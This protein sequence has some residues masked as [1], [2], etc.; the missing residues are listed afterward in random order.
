MS[1]SSARRQELLQGLHMLAIGQ[2][3]CD[4]PAREGASIYPRQRCSRAPKLL[5][6]DPA[7]WFLDD[8]VPTTRQLRDQR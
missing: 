2:R 7:P 5:L 3:Q 6:D 8:G 1:R 4:R